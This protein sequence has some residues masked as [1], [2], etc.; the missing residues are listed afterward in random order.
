MKTLSNDFLWGVSTSAFQ[1]EGENLNSQWHQWELAGRIRDGSQSGHA[2]GWWASA[3]ADL[4]RA[5]ALGLNA[6][7]I[8]LEW[9]RVEPVE[10]Q[11]NDEAICRYKRLLSEIRRRGM[12]PFACLHH[13]TNPQWFEQR[14]GFLADDAIAAFERFVYRIVEELRYD[15]SDWVTFNEPNV[16]CAFGYLIGEFP[17]GRQ[18][19]L[20]SALRVLSRMAI[21]HASAY[22]I[23]HAW[24]PKANVGWA[25]NF[26][27]FEPATAK[28]RDRIMAQV[29]DQLFN[30]AFIQL[31]R[32]GRLRH[33]WAA[34]TEP[35][36]VAQ[37]KLDFAGLNVYNRLH[38]ALDSRA[39]ETMFARIF[40]PEHLPQGDSAAQCAYGECH[41]DA[42]RAAVESVSSLDVPIY[43]LENGV[44]DAQDRLR[45][46]L[47]VRAVQTL[48]QLAAEGY[49]VRG[50]FHWTLVDCFEWTEGWRLRF[51]LYELDPV[52]QKRT[53]RPSASIYRRIIQARGVPDELIVQFG[54][55]PDCPPIPVEPR[56]QLFTDV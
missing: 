4:D 31:L 30:Q 28:R 2:C 6:L 12:R 46:W 29:L 48:L 54:Q 11:W 34:L 42:I 41:P 7:R 18:A 23:I 51:G 9:S 21:A 15:C 36:S 55:T 1:Y 53:P 45:P 33:P 17:P 37:G 50:Y 38:V 52:T 26:V 56:A 5:A 40:V 27:V 47:L 32:D 43:I 44:P 20:G 3:G 14:G 10:G 13:F 25:Q 24:Q 8:S 39:K 49:D 22:R 16:Y 19:D 35:A